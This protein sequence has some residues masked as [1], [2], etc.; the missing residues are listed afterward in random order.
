MDLGDLAPMGSEDPRYVVNVLQRLKY[1]KIDWP[2]NEE[3]D[4]YCVVRSGPELISLKKDIERSLSTRLIHSDR[5]DNTDVAHDLS[6]DT[7]VPNR[8]PGRPGYPYRP[9]LVR[10]LRRRGAAGELLDTLVGE[11][12]RLREWAEKEFPDV[13]PP[14]VKTLRNNH[15]DLYKQLKQDAQN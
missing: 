15:G 8:Y 13:Q 11:M 2:A 7:D 9:A 14:T 4:I 6:G 1:I 5:G 3:S 12:R 10:E